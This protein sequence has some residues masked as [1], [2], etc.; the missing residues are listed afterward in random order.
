MATISEFSD[1]YTYIFLKADTLV[2]VNFELS[3][4]SYYF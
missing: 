3:A 2:I 4:S 1:M